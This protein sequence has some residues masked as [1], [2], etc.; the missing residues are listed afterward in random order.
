MVQAYTGS[1]WGFGV[2]GSRC[3]IRACAIADYCVRG[4][5]TGEDALTP[6]NLIPQTLSPKSSTLNPNPQH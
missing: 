2:A 4:S 3:R 5:V 6:S 1:V